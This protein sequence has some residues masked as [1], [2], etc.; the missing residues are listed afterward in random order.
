MHFSSAQRLG[1]RLFAWVLFGIQAWCGFCCYVSAQTSS[2]SP[3]PDSL[4]NDLK[5][6]TSDELRGRS[7]VGETIL[8]AAEHIAERYREIG[9]DTHVINETPFQSV[10]M[11]VEPRPTES[12][13]NWMKVTHGKE[14]EFQV[15][16]DDGFSPLAI[17]QKE[18]RVKAPVAWVGYGIQASEHSYD[19][20]QGI[21]VSGRIVMMLRKEPAPADPKSPFDGARDSRYAAFRGKVEAAIQAGAAGVLLINDQASVER[22]SQSLTEQIR[23]EV[24]RLQRTKKLIDDLPDEAVK[25]REGLMASIEVINDTLVDVKREEQERQRGVLGI[26]QAG[27]SPVKRA[28]PPRGPILVASIGRDVAG[29]I[30]A[31]ASSGNDGESGGH[32]ALL[33]A[34]ESEINSTLKPNSQLLDGV[35]LEIRVGVTESKAKSPNVIGVLPGKGMLADETVVIGAHYDHVGMGGFGSLAPGTH[36]V[37]NGAD[38]NASGTAMLLQIADRSVALLG[39]QASHR[40]LVFIAFTG[41]ERGL[42]GSKHYVQ[43][44]RFPISKTVTMINLDMV[45]RLNDN[46]LTVYGTGSSP[47]FNSMLDEIESQSEIKFT[48]I[49]TGFGPSDHESFYSAGVPVLFFFT[50]LHNDYHRP[51]DDFEKLNL[52][53]M[54]R[55]TDIVC[56]VAVRVATASERPSYVKIKG[57]PVIRRQLTVYLGVSM[58]GDPAIARTGDGVVLSQVVPESPAAAAGLRVGDRLVSYDT[59]EIGTIDDLMKRLRQSAPGDTVR[60]GLVRQ[61][62]N[63]TIPV[64]LRAR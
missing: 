39:K 41:E 47:R 7:A 24:K 18:A 45:G 60:I 51:S 46:D 37:H 31:I 6:L 32:E 40:R 62:E 57:R 11:V 3:I 33:E 26:G 55:I 27:R 48:R 23:R 25:T 30:L 13:D 1:F 35:Q 21:D 58:S 54:I 17:G 50:G 16:L 56:Q 15:E 61:G 8:V 38:D 20:Y 34:K 22:D 9:L 42:L 63:L 36:A 2:D 43:Q 4:V 44:P 64:R 10:E 19:D 28:Q 53:G 14:A 49:E 59:K 12:A 52:G 5:R 29:R